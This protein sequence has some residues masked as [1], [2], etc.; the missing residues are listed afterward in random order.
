MREIQPTGG[1]G[2][3]SKRARER[4]PDEER[5]RDLRLPHRIADLLADLSDARRLRKHDGYESKR[6]KERTP[7]ELVGIKERYREYRRDLRLSHRVADLLADLPD[8]R[9]L[10]KHDSG[11]TAII[12][13]HLE[14]ALTDL[15]DGL[16]HGWKVGG[17]E[18]GE[19]FELSAERLLET[20][21]DDAFLTRTFGRSF[22]PAISRDLE[23]LWRKLNEYAP[24]E[25]PDLLTFVETASEVVDEL[26]ASQQA[27]RWND[28]EKS[29]LVLVVEFV[30]LACVEVLVAGLA[31]FPVRDSP[32]TEMIKATIV[33]AAGTVGKKLVTEAVASVRPPDLSSQLYEVTTALSTQRESLLD[34]LDAMDED[35]ADIDDLCG[36]AASRAA[37]LRGTAYVAQ[38]LAHRIAERD[39]SFSDSSQEIQDYYAKHARIAAEAFAAITAREP[40]DLNAITDQCNL[41][42]VDLLV[43]TMLPPR[44]GPDATGPAK[45]SISSV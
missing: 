45:G 14:F 27:G 17:T 6:A 24:A 33:V 35:R 42:T 5:R 7:A 36:L 2:Y 10:G 16:E 13:K 3:K 23:E 43:Q 38:R 4:T 32:I 25:R 28:R 11:D 19:V 1:D 18:S 39:E 26:L 12:L 20:S 8:A 37:D 15:R 30:A 31:A 40:S 22:H 21:L 9:R 41:H 44:W 34:V 29:L